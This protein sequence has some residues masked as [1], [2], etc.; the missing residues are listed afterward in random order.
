MPLDDVRGLRAGV[1]RLAGERRVRVGRTDD[2]LALECSGVI[3]EVGTPWQGWQVGDAVCAQLAGG[4]YAER[5]AVSVGQL[6]PPRQPGS[7]LRG[8]SA[9]GG[10]H[11]LVQPGMD[12]RLT[13]GDS[14]EVRLAD[15]H[16]GPSNSSASEES[17]RVLWREAD[18][19]E[20]DAA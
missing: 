17:L 1:E 7:R 10:F 18:H 5:V 3:S 13:A 20:R 8:S 6:M 19:A 14:E 9:G 2:L 4:G 16:P 11:G 15:V 12:A